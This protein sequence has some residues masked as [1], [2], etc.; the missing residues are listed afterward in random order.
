MSNK[1]GCDIFLPKI[2]LPL[3]WHL[4]KMPNPFIPKIANCATFQNIKK[5]NPGLHPS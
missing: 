2:F 3:P 1:N 5:K 4:R